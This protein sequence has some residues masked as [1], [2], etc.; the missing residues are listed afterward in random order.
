MTL[1]IDHP[2]QLH[3]IEMDWCGNCRDNTPHLKQKGLTGPCLYCA[4]IERPAPAKPVS[5]PEQLEM[6]PLYVSNY[7]PSPVQGKAR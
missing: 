2:F 5:M 1:K 7:Q 4:K 3:E 6:F